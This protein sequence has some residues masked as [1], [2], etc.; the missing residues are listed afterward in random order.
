MAT[1]LR[2]DSLVMRKDHSETASF[3][4]PMVRFKAESFLFSYAGS[5]YLDGE[6]KVEQRLLL[7]RRIWSSNKLGSFPKL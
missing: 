6:T 2:K 4:L 7:V 1:F 5:M 3:H